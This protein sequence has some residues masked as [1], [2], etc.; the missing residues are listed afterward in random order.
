MGAKSD[1]Q[2]RNRPKLQRCF[3]SAQS[4]E[5][6]AALAQAFA[7][8]GVKSFRADDFVSG[9]PLTPELL[10]QLEAADFMCALVNDSGSAPNIL[11]ELGAAHVLR[12][13]IILFTTNYDRLLGGLR[14]VYIVKA[15]I[16]DLASAASEID[17]FLRHAKAL[18]PIETGAG[19]RQKPNLAW[20]KEELTALRRDGTRDRGVRFEHLVG[21][22]F[23]RM[24]AEV[25]RGDRSE[26]DWAADLIVWLDEVAHEIG[27]PIII[28]CKYYGGGSGSVLMNAKHTVQQL[29]KHAVQQLEKYIGASEAKAA[30]I[31]YDHDRS[32]SLPSTLAIETPRVLVFSVDQLIQALEQ[33]TLANEILQ[34]R[35][36]ASYAR[37]SAGGPD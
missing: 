10:R 36:R 11:F 3:I 37:M 23:E 34:H 1:M 30:L 21:E 20:A 7:D 14:G 12:K 32:T 4:E 18:P 6:S 19:L 2:A 33:G 31:V 25:I 9:L 22:I 24:G 29:E 26:K 27:G 17:R 15:D 35:R 28:E 16:E 8:R 5:A 13:P